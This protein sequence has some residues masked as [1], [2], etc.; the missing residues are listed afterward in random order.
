MSDTA[1]DPSPWRLSWRADPAGRVLADR[2]YNRQSVGAK[3][4]V[5]PSRCLVMITGDRSALWVTSWPFAE[6]VK[7]DWAGAWVCSIFRNEG[8][9]LSSTLITHAVAHT[10]VRWPDVP[11]LGIVTFVDANKTRR[12]RDPGRCFRR[13]GWRHVGFTA[14]G[15]Y[16]LQQLPGE[17]PDPLSLPETQMPLWEAS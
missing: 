16:V 14:G 13:A 12:K 4:F 7:H 1:R 15:L 2:H 17:M 11:D 8:A 10:R 9:H 5:P 3:Q 6:Y